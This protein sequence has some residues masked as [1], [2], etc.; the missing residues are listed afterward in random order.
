MSI[1]QFFSFPKHSHN[2]PRGGLQTPK[3]PDLPG[4]YGLG[5]LVFLSLMTSLYTGKERGCGDV[6]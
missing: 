6:L 3:A 2:G 5:E 1:R 4:E